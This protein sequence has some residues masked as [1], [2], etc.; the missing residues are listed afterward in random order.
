VSDPEVLQ[1]EVDRLRAEIE[2]YRERELTELKTSL[3]VARQEAVHFRAEAQRNA[4]VGRQIASE[5][6]EQIATLRSQIESLRREAV[7]ARRPARS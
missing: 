7:N 4:D 2:S 1:A 6:Q 3:A 5:A